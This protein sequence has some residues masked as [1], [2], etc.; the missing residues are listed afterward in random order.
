MYMN[1]D[2]SS[3]N[4]P[5]LSEQLSREKQNLNWVEYAAYLYNNEDMSFSEAQCFLIAGKSLENYDEEY[6]AENTKYRF[7]HLRK[8]R[9]SLDFDVQIRTRKAEFEVYKP[10]IPAEKMRLIGYMSEIV[11]SKE[12]YVFI[13]VGENQYISVWHTYNKE[14]DTDLDIYAFSNYKSVDEF[15]TYNNYTKF[16]EHSN[17]SPTKVDYSDKNITFEGPLYNEYID[18]NF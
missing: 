16:M 17:W 11:G 13:S 2:L 4:I 15:K 8:E 12:S 9:D 7:T 5:S 3:T 6:L 1:T 10:I 18:S 14:Q